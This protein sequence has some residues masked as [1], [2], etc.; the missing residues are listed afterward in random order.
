MKNRLKNSVSLYKMDT[1]VK[2][3]V[4]YVSTTDSR[5]VFKIGHIDQGTNKRLP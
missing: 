3:S 1:G 2:T 4:I 5:D